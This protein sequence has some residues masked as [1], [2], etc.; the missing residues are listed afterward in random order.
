[1]AMI[2]HAS[3][4]AVVPVGQISVWA[5]KQSVVTAVAMIRTPVARRQ[6]LHVVKIKATN[7]VRR[8]YTAGVIVAAQTVDNRLWLS[9][10]NISIMACFVR[11]GACGRF[12]VTFSPNGTLIAT[13][14]E[15]ETSKYQI[16]ELT[17]YLQNEAG[18]DIYTVSRLTFSPNGQCLASSDKC[19]DAVTS[20]T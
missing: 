3:V 8:I 4:A 9:L 7:I 13:R 1:M 2:A 6:I 12:A 15:M 19:C 17:V 10:Q 14:T 20:D 5:R 11:Y 18:E 16:T